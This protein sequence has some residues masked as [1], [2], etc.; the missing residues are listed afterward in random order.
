MDPFTAMMLGST[1]I[2]GLGS[3]LG[4]IFGNKAQNDAAKRQAVTNPENTIFSAK[5]FMGRKYDEVSSETKRVPYKVVKATN[6]VQEPWFN[7]KFYGSF[8]F[9]PAP[10][11]QSDTLPFT[12]KVGPGTIRLLVDGQVAGEGQVT[13]YPA[14]AGAFSETFDIFFECF[15]SGNGENTGLTHT[16]AQHFS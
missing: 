10:G 13:T 4:G 3:L 8:A 9:V 16:S 6:G 12:S 5:R 15:L 14:V 7:S 2:S 11:G 1:A